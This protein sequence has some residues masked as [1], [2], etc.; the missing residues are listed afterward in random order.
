MRVQIIELFK[1]YLATWVL[2]PVLYYIVDFCINA[3]ACP[4]NVAPFMLAFAGH[5]GARKALDKWHTALW[6]LV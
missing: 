2:E 3:Q 4:A 1:I 5:L 6:A